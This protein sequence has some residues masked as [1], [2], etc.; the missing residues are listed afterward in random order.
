MKKAKWEVGELVSVPYYC[1]NPYRKGW[2]GWLFA[3]GVI[4][5]KRIGTGSKNANVPYA[6]VEYDHN[7]KTVQKVFKMENVF[8]R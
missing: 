5:E 7:G 6:L 2:N 8:A 4:V 1:F 3:N